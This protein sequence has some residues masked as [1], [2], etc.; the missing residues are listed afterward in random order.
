MIV[1][2]A[3]DARAW[4][5]ATSLVSLCIF[6]FSLTATRKPA[7]A[8]NGLCVQFL[9]LAIA[10]RQVLLGVL[11]V[12]LLAVV[13]FL[14]WTNS[15]SWEELLSSSRKQGRLRIERW[16]PLGLAG[17]LLY[18]GRKF[19]F[20]R[21]VSANQLELDPYLVVIMAFLFLLILMTAFHHLTESRAHK[22]EENH[23]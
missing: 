7:V 9:V 16:I 14:L 13:S 21:R 3:K 19:E 6:T 2:V 22:K 8:L 4:L 23:G 20:P 11:F 1:D 5:L 15:S 18:W 17:F 12:F 10:C